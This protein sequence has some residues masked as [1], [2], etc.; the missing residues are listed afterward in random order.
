MKTL[1]LALT[2]ALGLTACATDGYGRY[3]Y[4]PTDYAYDGYYDNHYGPV[5]GGYWGA[6]DVFYYRTSPNGRFIPDRDRHFRRDAYQGYDR[7]R[8]T[9][10]HPDWDRRRH[11]DRDRDHDR[12]HPR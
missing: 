2:L 3:D 6:N 7:V 1:G 8:V 5:M 4:G 9:G 10:P 12:D 11:H